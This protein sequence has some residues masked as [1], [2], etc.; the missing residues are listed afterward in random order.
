[1]SFVHILYYCSKPCSYWIADITSI[2]GLG[3]YN[4]SMQAQSTKYDKTSR[5][6]SLAV[7]S[8]CIWLIQISSLGTGRDRSNA[9][10]A[11]FVAAKRGRHSTT[12]YVV[13]SI[14]GRRGQHCQLPCFLHCTRGKWSSLHSASQRIENNW[15]F[16]ACERQYAEDVVTST[17]WGSFV[18]V[19]FSFL[20]VCVDGSRLHWASVTLAHC[21]TTQ[22]GPLEI[23]LSPSLTILP[24]YYRV[25]LCNTNYYLWR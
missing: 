3:T 15:F 4:V 25:I 7:F 12:I 8:C 16:K 21:K 13:W 18:V 1:M 5:S 24:R 22:D 9:T 14:D 17:T 19:V 23:S 11:T 6:L 10:K 2:T 20:Y